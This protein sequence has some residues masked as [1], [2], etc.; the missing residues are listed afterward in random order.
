M[1]W[2]DEPP[3][4]GFTTGAP[5]LP[6]PQEYGRLTV[7]A[8]L[9]DVGSTLSLYRRALELRANHP[10]FA[11]DAVEWYG[12]P[13]G[14]FA[15]RRSASTLVC[16]LNASAAPVPL[17]PGDVLLTSVPLVDGE[18]PPNAAAWLT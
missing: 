3:G 10:G 4:Y 14:C 2:V 5:W 17:P 8:Q 6:M 11:G 18:L 13:P 12:A 1:P 7:A 9:E 16:A 15:F